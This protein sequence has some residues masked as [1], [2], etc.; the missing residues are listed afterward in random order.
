MEDP[1][2]AGSLKEPGVE[3]SKVP[4]TSRVPTWRRAVRGDDYSDKLERSSSGCREREDMFCSLSV[5]SDFSPVHLSSP[6][7]RVPPPEC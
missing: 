5:R 6:L 4:L 3:G 7:P 1:K 2:L